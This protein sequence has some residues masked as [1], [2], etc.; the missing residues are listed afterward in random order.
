MMKKYPYNILPFVA[1][2]IF[3]YNC[4]FGFSPQLQETPGY[5]KLTI[6]STDEFSVGEMST[7][8]GGKILILRGNF[9]DAGT[10]YLFNEIHSSFLK[11]LVFQKQNEGKFQLILNGVPSDHNIYYQLVTDSVY[12]LDVFIFAPKITS[13]RDEALMR[14]LEGLEAERNGE[15]E[16]ALSLYK[17]ITRRYQ[18]DHI[19]G[20]AY[21][22]AGIIRFL[23]QDLKNAE[24]NFRLSLRYGTDSI[25]VY[26]YLA[27]LYEKMNNPTEAAKNLAIIKKWEE[28]VILAR[29]KMRQQLPARIEETMPETK[30]HSSSDQALPNGSWAAIIMIIGS[31]FLLL[32]LWLFLRKRNQ[33]DIGE[34]TTDAEDEEEPSAEFEEET[35][36]TEVLERKKAEI[37]GQ[38]EENPEPLITGQ[39]TGEN[40]SEDKPVEQDEEGRENMEKIRKARELNIGVGEIDLALNLKEKLKSV[41]KLSDRESLIL[42]MFRTGFTKEE[43]AKKLQLNYG[44]VELVIELNR[45]KLKK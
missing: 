29:E 19:V 21:Y 39:S 37:T 16:K 45:H 26:S 31:V 4:V 14:Y 23:R 40:G 9:Q 3:T 41:N 2:L 7:L 8:P 10:D 20:N 13:L 25:R 34:Y 28:K 5:L 36:F 33:K 35:N 42:E 11:S 43:I 22:R 1:I 17:L 30:E 18:K 27:K 12:R 24:T 6:S 44:E 15:P 32:G 38:S